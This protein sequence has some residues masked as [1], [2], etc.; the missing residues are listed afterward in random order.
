VPIIL[1]FN[2]TN[3]VTWARSFSAIFGQYG[4]HDHVNTAAKGDNDWVQND[5][6]IVSWFYNRISPEL[7]SMV[8]EDTDTAYSI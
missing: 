5:C 2:D 6:A 3:Y 4:L 8:S 1:D 7:L